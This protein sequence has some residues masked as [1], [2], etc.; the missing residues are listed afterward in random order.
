MSVVRTGVWVNKPPQGSYMR[1]CTFLTVRL[2]R[3]LRAISLETVYGAGKVEAL[4]TGGVLS[5]FQTSLCH[6]NGSLHSYML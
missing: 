2:D 3:S 4:C 1:V 6:S 5:V